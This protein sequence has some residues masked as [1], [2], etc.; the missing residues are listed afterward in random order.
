MFNISDVH[1]WNRTK[2][3]VVDLVAEL[4][5]IKSNFRNKNL[6]IHVHDT[7]SDCVAQAD[8]IVT[9]TFTS[10]P[11][12]FGNMLKSNAHINGTLISVIVQRPL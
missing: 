5:D 2:S 8:I 1:L 3:K 11:F 12:L 7:V 4:E 6:K 10:S 9:A